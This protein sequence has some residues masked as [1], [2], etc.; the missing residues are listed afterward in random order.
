MSIE[1]F[2]RYDLNLLLLLHVLLEEGGVTAAAQRLGLT[3]GAASRALG[4]LREQLDDELL[5][6]M[7]GTM[8]PTPRATQMKEPL[9]QLLHRLGN[10]LEPEVELKLDD[11][12]RELTVATA[13]YPTLVLFPD[14]FLAL[15]KEAPHIRLR[16]EPIDDDTM[17]RLS[18]GEIDLVMA[19]RLSAPAGVVWSQLEPEPFVAIARRDHP[20][21]HQGLTL[22]TFLEYEHA[23]VCP[24]RRDSEGV[25]DRALASMGKTRK[26]AVRVPHFAAV[27]PLVASSDLLATLPRGM[28]LLASD[29]YPVDRFDPPLSL[30]P[31]RVAIGWHERVRRDPLHSWFR[32]LLAEVAT[33]RAAPQHSDP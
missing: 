19:P 5:V 28:A 3:Q 7:G 22:E 2:R 14:L 30:P 11:V 29:S 21:T 32:N 26:V 10:L 13:D 12:E 17:N 1:K 27:P 4:R 20:A 15:R 23:L 6:R 31:V 18:F 33:S 16:V 25:V 24:S 8:V 9:E